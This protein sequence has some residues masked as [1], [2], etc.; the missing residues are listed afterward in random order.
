MLEVLYEEQGLGVSGYISP[1]SLT[2]AH[3]RDIFFFINGRPVQDAALSAALVK[4][5]HSLLMVGR[6]PMAVL[7]VEMS[8][9][10]VDVNVHPTKAEVR[11]REP[12]RIFSSVQN[13]VRRALLAHSPVPGLGDELRWAPGP[14]QMPFQR[15]IDPAWDM[16]DE[17]Q[18]LVLGSSDRLKARQPTRCKSPSQR[19]PLSACRCCVRW[20]RSPTPIWSPRGRMACT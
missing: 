18:R 2:R 13:A 19:S 8:P 14:S 4:G 9:E 15:P 10:S 16:L 5:Y 17:P 3:R 12:D 11:F 20:A 7:F 1:V 6:Y